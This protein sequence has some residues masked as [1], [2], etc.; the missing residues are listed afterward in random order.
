MNDG[1]HHANFGCKLKFP[2][3]QL[4]TLITIV[5]HRLNYASLAL[6]LG[7]NLILRGLKNLFFINWV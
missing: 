6:C 1:T 7:L 3:N 4:I 5:G 2:Q